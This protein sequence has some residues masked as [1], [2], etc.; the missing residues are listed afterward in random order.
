MSLVK[1][2]CIFLSVIFTTIPLVENWFRVMHVYL[3]L[4]PRHSFNGFEKYLKRKLLFILLFVHDRFQDGHV[5]PNVVEVLPMSTEKTTTPPSVTITKM[6]TTTEKLGKHPIHTNIFA[7]RTHADYF[8]SVSIRL[9]CLK[10]TYWYTLM[11]TRCTTIFDIYRS[12]T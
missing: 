10:T 4:F 6:T 7:N 2:V 9:D 3:L 5:R 12:D 8:V 1:C 11:H